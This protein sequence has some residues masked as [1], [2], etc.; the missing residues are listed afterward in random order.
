MVITPQI[1]KREIYFQPELVMDYADKT[2]LNNY[3]GSQSSVG[4]QGFVLYESAVDFFKKL[5]ISSEE[6]AHIPDVAISA[7][8][9]LLKQADDYEK[10]LYR[11]VKAHKRER[12]T[13]TRLRLQRDELRAMFKRMGHDPMP[14][15]KSQELQVIKD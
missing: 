5:G 2:P 15:Y 14:N 6:I 4:M 8:G 7:I 3:I 11:V 12:K 13:S 9:N 10:D 1:P